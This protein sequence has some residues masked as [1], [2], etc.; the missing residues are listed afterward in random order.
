MVGIELLKD[1]LEDIL[2]TTK[3]PKANDACHY[4]K[5]VLLPTGYM[6]VPWKWHPDIVDVQIFRIGSFVIAGVPGEFTTMAGAPSARGAP[7]YA[8]ERGSLASDRC[9]RRALESLVA[10]PPASPL[11]SQYVLSLTN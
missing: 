9:D 8:R 4:P 7:R 2:C 6:D 1:V 5:P 3:P 11:G 10:Q